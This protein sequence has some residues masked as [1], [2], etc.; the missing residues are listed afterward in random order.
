MVQA[1][2]FKQNQIATQTQ[3]TQ[4]A[5]KEHPMHPAHYKVNRVITDTTVVQ[6]HH[7][8]QQ[9]Q[10]TQQPQQTRKEY[11][12][13][14]AQHKA[15]KV[16]GAATGSAILGGIVACLTPKSTTVKALKSKAGIGTG[17]VLFAANLFKGFN[18]KYE[19]EYVARKTVFEKSINS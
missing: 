11:P 7:Q 18:G 6:N 5:G 12:I 9:S 10:K 17:L 8:P 3:Q 15:N 1:I 16:V 13:S 2:S 4:Q 19:A 14:P